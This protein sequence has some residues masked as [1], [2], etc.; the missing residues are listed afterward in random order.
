[1]PL[2]ARASVP[3]ARKKRTVGIGI[4]ICMVVRLQTGSK[5]E[6]DDEVDG[7]SHVMDG[8]WSTSIKYLSVLI[9]VVGLIFVYP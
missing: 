5:I 9:C 3:M 8:S 7:L 1:M 4:D 6:N 2:V